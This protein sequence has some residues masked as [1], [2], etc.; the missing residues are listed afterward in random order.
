[1]P[2]S[3]SCA[4]RTARCSLGPLARWA[5]RLGRCVDLDHEERAYKLEL[6]ARL[7]AARQALMAGDKDWVRLLKRAFGPPNNLTSW[8]AHGILLRWAANST[9]DA[10]E[11]LRVLWEP[12]AAPAVA[13]GRFCERLPEDVPRPGTAINLA[14]YLLGA[15]DVEQRPVYRVTLFEQAFRLT[16]WTALGGEPGTQYADALDFLDAFSRA[17]SAAGGPELRDRLDAQGLL[18]QV[19]TTG[20]HPSW[21][22]EEKRA[23]RRFLKGR[24]VD[25][26]TELVA[27]FRE[28][29]DYPA[30]RRAQRDAERL[31]LAEG[32]TPDTLAEPDLALLRRLAGSAYGSPGPQ[33]GFNRLLRDEHEVERVLEMLRHL[34]YGEGELTDR[35]DDCIVGPQRLHGVGEAM[36]VKALAVTEPERWIP[37]YVTNGA[38][39]K[40]RI[41]ELMG[42][43]APDGLSPGAAAA[44]TNDLLRE[45]LEPHFPEDPWGMQEFSWWLLHREAV[46]HAPLKSLAEELLLPEEFLARVLSLAEDR[47]QVVLYGPPGTGKTYVARKLAGHLARGGGTVEKVQFHPSYAYEDFVEG[48][49]PKLVDGQMTY[50]VVDGPL[51]RIAAAAEQRKDLVHVL[52]IDELNRANVAKVLG[53]LLFLLEY[54][55]EEIT[56]QYSE[57]S[58]SL[59]DNLRIIATMNTADRSVALVDAALRRRFH[60][61]PFFPDTPPIDALL[62]R[63]LVVHQPQLLWVADLVDRANAL[64]GDRNLAIGPSHFLKRNLDEAGVQLAW[65]HSILPFLEEYFFS[66][67]DRLEEFSLDRLRA[68]APPPAVEPPSP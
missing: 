34:I 8:R 60:F 67:P 52:L 9:E 62:R 6:G 45:R 36:A 19:L 13:V 57:T 14:S 4:S 23:F 55:D 12:G 5:A 1:V 44:A 61:V 46:P 43:A 49:R 11:A 40:R 53:E 38:V 20:P 54:R 7:D 51:K 29:T 47:G 17:V 30:G 63:W 48:Y 26:L 18:W 2:A 3:T 64:L 35:L 28:A 33:P 37:C 59:P 65:E 56:L 42:A 50:E 27:E 10:A 68:P 39:G 22:D 32:L 58:F 66:D 15:V 21:N 24:S 16:G 31:E 41:L 25:E